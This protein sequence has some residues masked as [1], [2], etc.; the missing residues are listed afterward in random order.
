MTNVYA[1]VRLGTD[2]IE[3]L[4]LLRVMWSRE[5]HAI[6]VFASSNTH[7]HQTD[8]KKPTKYDE[9]YNESSHKALTLALNSLGRDDLD[10]KKAADLIR[11]IAVSK[12]GYDGA[13]LLRSTHRPLCL[14]MRYYRQEM[15]S[16]HHWRYHP[17]HGHPI[18]F[19]LET[20]KV[21]NTRMAPHLFDFPAYVQKQ[22]F[23]L[24]LKAD[25]KIIIDL[26]KE[27][28][29]LPGLLL[30][31]RKLYD[32]SAGFYYTANDFILT[33]HVQRNYLENFDRRL[34]RWMSNNC[35]SKMSTKD[36][37]GLKGRNV[38]EIRFISKSIDD[39]FWELS[40]L[41][42]NT[43]PLMRY[44]SCLGNGSST[45]QVKIHVSSWR[46]GLDGSEE[47]MEHTSFGSISLRRTILAAIGE[48]DG[49]D[50]DPEGGRSPGVVVNGHGTPV[51]FF[52]MGQDHFVSDGIG[53][54]C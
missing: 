36:V 54:A 40:Q 12:Y 29:V 30:V 19:A 7:A 53:T 13:V 42:I 37:A 45:G 21:V 41:Q 50:I 49:G 9:N 5:C 22:I 38:C 28:E 31:A 16:T 10:I 18:L 20:D 51:E 11:H 34:D 8:L 14:P 15:G 3:L 33:R 46:T 25:D 4:P 43:A 1:D 27:K 47:L 32:W 24:A 6:I 44:A 26:D 23:H 2:Y 48:I 52:V 17:C 35:F 39:T